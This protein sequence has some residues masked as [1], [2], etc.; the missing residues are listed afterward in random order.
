MSIPRYK[1]D[2]V[3]DDLVWSVVN[4]STKKWGSTNRRSRSKSEQV[5]PGWL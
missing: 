1:V 4:I 5:V 2:N 3:N